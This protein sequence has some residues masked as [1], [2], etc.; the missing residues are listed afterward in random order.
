MKRIGMSREGERWN[1]WRGF[2]REEEGCILVFSSEVLMTGGRWRWGRIYGLMKMGDFL[3]YFSGSSL[4]FYHDAW[5]FI[6]LIRES[7][8][9]VIRK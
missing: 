7:F 2:F 6:G 1:G 8:G 5:I 3:G 4:S 9:G